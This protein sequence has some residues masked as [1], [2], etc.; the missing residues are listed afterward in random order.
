MEMVIT[1]DTLTIDLTCPKGG[2]GA[3]GIT[4]KI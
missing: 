3:R 1:F 4:Y 2:Q